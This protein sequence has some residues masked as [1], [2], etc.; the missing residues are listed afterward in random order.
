MLEMWEFHS[1]I[2]SSLPLN[3][4]LSPQIME[5]RAK[6]WNSSGKDAAGDS[7]SCSFRKGIPGGLVG[8]GTPRDSP[9]SGGGA[10]PCPPRSQKHP[11]NNPGCKSRLLPVSDG[12]PA[13][14]SHP[15]PPWALPMF[16]LPTTSA[17]PEPVPV[18]GGSGMPSRDKQGFGGCRPSEVPSPM[19]QRDIFPSLG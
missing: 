17:A 11:G 13:R 15:I 16:V 2:A 4:L 12:T 5:P 6:G 3:H 1:G 10:V 9:G 8:P 18:P 7:P 19:I 14:S